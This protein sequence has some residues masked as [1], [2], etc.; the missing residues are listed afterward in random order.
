MKSIQISKDTSNIIKGL[1][2]LL[3]VAHH[4]CARLIGKG[5]DDLI[6]NFIGIRGGVIGVTIFFFLSA[7]GL[8][9]SQGKNQYS[10]NVFVKR[11]LSKVYVPLIITNIIYYLFL[12]ISNKISF[13]LQGFILNALNIKY[14]DGVLWFCNTILIF[15][16]IFYLS[17]LPKTKYGKAG[18][19]LLSTLVYSVLSTIIFPDSPF[20]VYSIIGFP[21]GMVCSLYKENMLRLSYWGTW[22]FIGLLILFIGALMIP[23]YRN[24]FLMNSFCFILLIVILSIL[25][26]V[27]I[28]KKLIVLPF[29]GIYSYEIYL[30]HNKVLD[31]LGDAGYTNW[32]PIA[33]LMIVIPLSVL[34]NRLV[35][36]ILK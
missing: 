17:F 15:Y 10:F 21:F 6:I 25:Q 31:P 9:E 4:F 28:S 16:L 33:F 8:S 34:L 5:S 20:Y 27:T 24:L 14:I 23:S 12:W 36:V 1:A 19:C 22:S 18:V 13:N 2:C 32:Y 11:R 26:R 7:W 30:L 29:I 3:I 35:K